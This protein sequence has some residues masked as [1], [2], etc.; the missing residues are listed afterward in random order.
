MSKIKDRQ[1]QEYLSEVSRSLICDKKQKKAIIG[2]LRADVEGFVAE[3][4]ET[5]LEDIIGYFGS[6]ESISASFMENVD[7][8]K[9]KRSL[10]VKKVIVIALV[11]ALVIY[12]LFVVIS[13]VDVHDEA[14]G[15]IEEGIMMI[16]NNFVGGELI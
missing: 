3:N 10:D 4:D 8:V 13:L 11:L 5:S 16:K 15:Y 9:L 7:T 14:H 6:A 1:L 12:V 2:Q